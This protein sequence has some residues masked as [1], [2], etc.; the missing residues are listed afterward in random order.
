MLIGLMLFSLHLSVAASTSDQNSSAFEAGIIV[1]L[2]QELVKQADCENNQQSECD[3]SE[4][5]A[6]LKILGLYQ[7]TEQPSPDYPVSAQ[8]RGVN[9]AVISDLTIAINGQVENVSTVECRSGDGDT[10]LQWKWEIDGELCG[11]FSRAAEKSFQAYKFPSLA[12]LNFT[13]PRTIRWRSVF[14]LE[15]TDSSDLNSQIV[16]LDER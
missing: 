1:L 7:P 13:E 9:G 10:R 5:V 6:F 4:V 12:H 3:D 11:D 8:Y 15:G 2:R 14:T 16:D